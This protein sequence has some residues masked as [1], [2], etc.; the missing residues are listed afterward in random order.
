MREELNALRERV[1]DL[2]KRLE[3]LERKEQV[4]DSDDAAAPPPFEQRYK[5]PE[6]FRVVKAPGRTVVFV[7][8][9]SMHPTGDNG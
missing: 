3:A 7:G 9:G 4:A 8:A 1:R 2:Q 5:I 6:G